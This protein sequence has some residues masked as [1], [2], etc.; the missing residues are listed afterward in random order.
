MSTELCADTPGFLAGILV[1]AVIALASSYFTSTVVMRNAL[2]Q[3]EHAKTSLKKQ[4]TQY[5]NDA[6]QHLCEDSDQE[7]ESDSENEDDDD[8]TT[9]GEE[10]T[11]TDNDNDDNEPEPTQETENDE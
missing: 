5:L 10:T 6:T 4:S 7:S 8:T 9:S 2:I 3:Y 11:D 1:G